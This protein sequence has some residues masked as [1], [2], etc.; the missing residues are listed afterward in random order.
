MH[1]NGCVYETF[2]IS[3]RLPIKLQ[4]LLIRAETLDK[5]LTAKCFIHDVELNPPQRIAL[6]KVPGFFYYLRIFFTKFS[7]NEKETGF[8]YG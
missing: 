1:D 4:L 8:Y 6:L 2:G 5:P 3:K 7:D